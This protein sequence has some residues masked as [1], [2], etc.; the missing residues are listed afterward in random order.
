MKHEATLFTREGGPV[1]WQAVVLPAPDQPG[2]ALVRLLRESRLGWWWESVR[3]HPDQASS[4]PLLPEARPW[5]R[6][7]PGS[8]G[9]LLRDLAETDEDNYRRFLALVAT[10]A[11]SPGPESAGMQDALAAFCRREEG[12]VRAVV[13]QVGDSVEE[14]VF[15]PHH[16]VPAVQA[17]LAQWGLDAAAPR[18]RPYRGLHKAALEALYGIDQ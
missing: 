12:P 6:L 13:V 11:D 5:T 18:T 1:C 3:S 15:V 10:D 8:E 14:H 2:D 9:D 17:L 16:P 4:D 7:H